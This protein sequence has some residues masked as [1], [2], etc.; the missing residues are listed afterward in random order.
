M[1]HDR[2]NSEVTIDV[3]GDGTVDARF[4]VYSDQN[5][6]A[7]L[8][9]TT[10]S[11]VADPMGTSD[12]DD[13]D[14]QGT[15]QADSIDAMG[16]NDGVEAGFG[17]DTVMGGDGN[18][19]LSGEDGADVL[20][21]GDG[22]DTLYGGDDNDVLNGGAGHDYIDG[23]E[24]NDMLSGG[25][26]DDTLLAGDGNDTVNS[27]AGN[28]HVNLGN[29]DDVVQGSVDELDGDD[30]DSFNDDDRIEISGLTADSVITHNDLENMVEI[31]VDGDGEID[32]SFELYGSNGILGEVRSADG[33]SAVLQIDRSLTSNADND[34]WV[35]AVMTRLTVWREM[36]NC[37]ALVAVT[38]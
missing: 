35:P 13:Y 29:G 37:L 14:V 9:G 18:D 11:L 1:T 4:A 25:D 19:W 22:N 10:V 2:E 32:A 7:T 6:M 38:P 34:A 24:D 27:G 23:G 36:T 21:G 17:D 15:D 12:L 5:M 16:G 3:D 26:G 20:D 8:D 31:D 33:T 28:D 30:I